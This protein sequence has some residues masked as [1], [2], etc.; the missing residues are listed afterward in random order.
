MLLAMRR[1]AVLRGAAPLPVHKTILGYEKR[2]T[3]AR[4]SLYRLPENCDT[5]LFPGCTFPGTRPGRLMELFK[6][7]QQSIP[8]L[9]IVLDCCTKPSHDLGQVDYFQAMF[10]DLRDYLLTS[11]IKKVLVLCP[12]CFRVFDQ[13]GAPLVVETVY[14]RLLEHPVS[15]GTLEGQVTVHDPCSIRENSSAQQAVRRLITAASLEITEM[16]H[17]RSRTICCGEGGSAGFVNPGF[18]DNWGKQR[19]QE[20][21][22]MLVVTYCAGC[23]NFLGA[24]MRACHI[25][26]LLFD[27]QASLADRV[28]VARAPFT[29]LNRLLL[30]H[31]FKKLLVNASQRVRRFKPE[32]EKL[33]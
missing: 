26:D 6:H 21:G 32:K 4:Y 24:R 31:C 25:L 20:A 30:K 12:N 3:S 13:Y 1:E 17:N 18:A 28:K 7:L 19:Q 5:V 23:V 11:K 2:G 33:P 14:T 10:D 8:N 27:P 9:G 15:S 29:Y 22:T 16:E